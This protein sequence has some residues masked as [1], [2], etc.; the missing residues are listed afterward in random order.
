M[1]VLV[2]LLVSNGLP[3][4]AHK[5]QKENASILY[6]GIERVM[7]LVPSSWFNPTYST[8]EA[9]S[10]LLCKSMSRDPISSGWMDR[11]KILFYTLV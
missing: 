11:P 8:F 4:T 6:E 5:V 10:N 1:V 2:E 7:L 3:P 9:G